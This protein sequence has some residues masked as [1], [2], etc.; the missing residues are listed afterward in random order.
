MITCGSSSLPH[1]YRIWRLPGGGT[2]Y[3]GDPRGD[4]E[5]EPKSSGTRKKKDGA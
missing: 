2:F 5:E 1:P 3:I 4:D